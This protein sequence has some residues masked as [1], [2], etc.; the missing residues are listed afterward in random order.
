M[1]F[2]FHLAFIGFAV[3]CPVA[4]GQK[5]SFGVVGGVN[6]TDDL[7]TLREPFAYLGNT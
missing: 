7:R 3:V 2:G 1:K 5:L 4:S 6:L